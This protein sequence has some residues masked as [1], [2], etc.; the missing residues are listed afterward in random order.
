MQKRK[1]FTGRDQGL[2]SIRATNSLQCVLVKTKSVSVKID[3]VKQ[4]MQKHLLLSNLKEFNL[5]FKKATDMKIGFSR[6]YDLWLKWC[7]PVESASGAHSV[8]VCEY[9]QNAK[10]MVFCYTRCH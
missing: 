2:A 8:G 4:R 6:F 3:G 1:G 7:V 5:E 10:R 9:H